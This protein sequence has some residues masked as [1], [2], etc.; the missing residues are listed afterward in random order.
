MIVNYIQSLREACAIT[1][2]DENNMA[3]EVGNHI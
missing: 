1:T 3:E 2:D